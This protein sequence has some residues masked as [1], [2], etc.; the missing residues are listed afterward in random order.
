MSPEHW[1]QVDE[2]FHRVREQ[3]SER[4]LLLAEADPE[5]RREVESLLAQE[6][7]QFLSSSILDGQGPL[8]PGTPLG[9]YRIES[10]LGAGGM[11]EVYQAKDTL[12]GREVALKLLPCDRVADAD[13][14][15]RIL[16]E[17]RAVSAL[18]HPNI[19]SLYDM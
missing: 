2:V 5:V 12:L 16:L 17:A 4:D 7:I 13:R 15:R 19:V 10:L 1:A 6:P 11:G 3:P 8:P 14:R 18:S 9:R